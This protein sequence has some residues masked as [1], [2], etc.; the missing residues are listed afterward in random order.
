MHRERPTRRQARP[1]GDERGFTM[2]ELLV[3]ILIVAIMAAI[4]LPAFLNQRAKGEDTEAKLAL[5]TAATALRTFEMNESTFNATL[6][7]LEA[8][9]PALAEARDLRVTGTVDTFELIEE[10][11]DGTIFTLERDA[12]GEM[13][14]DCS[15]PGY[16]LC[17]QDLD[18]RGN[19]W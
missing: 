11:A 8:I 5:R 9:E 18:A 6:G 15:N 4:A 19:R 14:R 16:G 3:C 10:S 17:R 13:T 7:Q 12:G 2:V 1:F